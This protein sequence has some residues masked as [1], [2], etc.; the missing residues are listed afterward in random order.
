MKPQEKLF[1]Y[2]AEQLTFGEL[3]AL[4]IRTGCKGKS[5]RQISEDITP[6]IHKNKNTITPM[7]F[8]GVRGLG[9]AKI[10]VLCAA[11][12]LGHRLY[13]NKNTKLIVN[14][15]DV[16]LL[17]RDEVQKK[18]EYFVVFYLN[19]RN[20]M[21]QKEVVSI[22]S[23][24]TSIAHPREV[25]EPAVRHHAG[26]IILAHNHPSGDPT[27]SHEDKGTTKRLVQAGEILGIEVVDHVVVTK[28]GFVSMKE[29]GMM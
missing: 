9:K 21:I 25:F 29:K 10:S 12:E 28:E 17:M 3:G 14:P 26:Q 20:Q 2:G 1:T 13:G 7:L 23:L 27:P 15:K 6:L 18:K 11:L 16:W 24:N 22:G 4:L 19:T 8:A 5:A